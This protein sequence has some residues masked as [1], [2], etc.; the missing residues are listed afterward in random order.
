VKIN[1]EG[2]P[3]RANTTTFIIRLSRK[4][5]A[6]RRQK[7]AR[8]LA[9][10][11]HKSARQVSHAHQLTSQVQIVTPER[12]SAWPQPTQRQ[13]NAATCDFGRRMSVLK[14]IQPQ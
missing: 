6:Q 11:D 1:R 2:K 4:R 14:G 9:A 7:G 12:G 3:P 13:G 8:V 5:Q 10:L